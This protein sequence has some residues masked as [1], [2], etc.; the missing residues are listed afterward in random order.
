[1][2]P[3]LENLVSLE[4]RILTWEYNDKNLIQLQTILDQAPRLYHLKFLSWPSGFSK[5]EHKNK[6]VIIRTKIFI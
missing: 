3:Q 6:K 1:M 2:V 5:G 4:I